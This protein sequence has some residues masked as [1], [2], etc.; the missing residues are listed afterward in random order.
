MKKLFISLIGLV[1]VLSGCSF[2]TSS[3][4][5][6]PSQEQLGNKKIS[7]Q[8]ATINS[9]ENTTEK[10]FQALIYKRSTNSKFSDKISGTFYTNF[11]GS[12]KKEITKSD[13]LSYILSRPLGAKLSPDGSKVVY[14]ATKSNYNPDPGS[15][16]YVQDVYV[17]NSDGSDIQPLAMNISKNLGINELYTIIGWSYDN[18]IYFT[19]GTEIQNGTQKPGLWSFDF[20]SKLVKQINFSN[21][22][23]G[24][25]KISSDGTKIA[26]AP[27][28]KSSGVGD[29]TPSEPHML[30][31]LDLTTGEQVIIATATDEALF[32]YFIWSKDGLKLIY[33]QYEEVERGFFVY[34]FISKRSI[35]ILSKFNPESILGW[36]S[37]QRVA[38]VVRI[39]NLATTNVD[40]V[41][42]LHSVKLDE[43]EDK[44]L[45]SFIGPGSFNFVDFG[46]Y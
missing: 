9:D 39:Q 35:Q 25:A 40:D 44:V 15:F 5:Q 28:D 3:I 37:N 12:I 27:Y 11:D 20:D 30:K 26:Y 36:L 38:Y 43:S 42:S 13:E 19:V 16:S 45:D 33:S 21:E 4:N 34:N 18:K 6:A 1:V 2:N 41:L 22:I 31:I 10:D 29:W 17:M 23:F 7:Q 46:N 14:L 8:S 24:N 32:D